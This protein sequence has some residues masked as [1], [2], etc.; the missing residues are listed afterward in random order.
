M[1]GGGAAAPRA[2]DSLALGRGLG[3]ASRGPQHSGRD[4]A[5]LGCSVRRQ[6]AV[7]AGKSGFKKKELWSAVRRRP[8]K[9]RPRDAVSEE[10]GLSC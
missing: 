5:R 2:Q 3:K 4:E 8:N 9:C 7:G 10:G 6:L 1:C